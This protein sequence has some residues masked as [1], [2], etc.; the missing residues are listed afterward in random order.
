MRPRLIVVAQCHGY[1]TGDAVHGMC[2]ETHGAKLYGISGVMRNGFSVRRY[3]ST[4]TPITGGD[5]VFTYASGTFTHATLGTW[6]VTGTVPHVGSPWTPENFVLVAPPT[7][8]TFAG[9]T[10]TSAAA[11]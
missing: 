6:T 3:G 1:A 5:L 8:G 4:G 7:A 9:N 2:W 10:S 11:C